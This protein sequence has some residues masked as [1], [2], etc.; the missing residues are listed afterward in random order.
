[1]A[2]NYYEGLYILD[3]NKYAR[4]PDGVVRQI[5]DV[6]TEFGAE[7]L[8]SRIWEERRLAYPIKKQRR[9]TYWLIYFKA[10]STKMGEI[11]RR[12]Q[13]APDILRFMHIKI[14]PRIIDVLVEH[15]R[16]GQVAVRTVNEAEL[17][18]ADETADDEVEEEAAPSADALE[19]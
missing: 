9:G 10:E 11:R 17:D 1:M 18:I 3:S 19:D 14:D 6:L 12:L 4:D 13:L 7:I 8:V 16:G 15:A 5:T 2:Q